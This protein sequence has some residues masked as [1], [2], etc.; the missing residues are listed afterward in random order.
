MVA[1]PSR[2]SLL[3]LAFGALIS[4][5]A[6]LLAAGDR[7]A[8]AQS[9]GVAPASARVEPP[10][11][12]APATKR[13]EPAPGTSVRLR[14]RH[15]LG[16]PLHPAPDSPRVSGR[17]PDGSFARVISSTTDAR[18]F[19]L[20]AEG[21]RGFVTRRYLDL[22]DLEQSGVVPSDSPWSSRAACA[23]ALK[24]P[25]AARDPKRVRVG[26]WNLRWFPDGRPG[27]AKPDGGTDL[28]W[29]A[30]TL[31]LLEVD[32]LAVEEIKH[33]PAAQQAL[34]ALSARLSEL[35]GGRFR[36]F[37]DDCP[38]G[39]SQHVGFLYDESRARLLERTT[40]AELNPHGAPCKDQLR[41]G[42]A[43]YFSFPGGLDLT[44]VAVHLKS[45]PDPRA[46]GLR[47]RSF[48]AFA[49][50]AERLRKL[51]NDRDILVLGD[52]NT[53]GCES[54]TP[55]LSAESELE[56]QD[57]RLGAAGFR[58]VPSNR[59][60]S[61]FYGSKPTLLDWAAAHDLAELPGARSALVSGICGELAGARP[62]GELAAQRRL[63]DHCPV[64]LELDDRDAD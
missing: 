35:R 16:V 55:P 30:C 48:A 58:R 28:E 57:K 29:L 7:D 19:E 1:R 36:S 13:A 20:E 8:S 61:H 59:T 27:K 22:P 32:V 43:G 42:L 9:S 49:S 40:L 23:A 6:W 33:G 44:L 60:A 17:L 37:L 45:G 51:T 54:C 47:D 12:P 34:L 64:V 11:R 62:R 38:R 53:M 21:Q 3:A 63:S 56:R 10:A 31:A 24:R 46:L 15:T 14:A 25:G 26:A 18:W 50:A 4:G 39:A 52:M 41:P 5:S 2:K